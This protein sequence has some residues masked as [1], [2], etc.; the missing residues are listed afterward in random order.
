MMMQYSAAGRQLTESSEGLSL[1]AYADPGTGGKPYTIGYGRAHGVNPGDV[2]T[3]AQAEQWLM[4]DI[5]SAVDTVNRLVTFPI[6]QAQFDS[7]VDFA[8]NAGSG[9][10]AGSTLLKKVNAGD[11]TGAQAEFGKWIYGGGRVL[12]G[13]VRRRA[14]EAAMFGQQNERI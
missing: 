5:Q 6:T 13:L 12:A 8:F 9:N 3:Q 7:L 11:M 2:C 10:F 14:A 1:I 4:E